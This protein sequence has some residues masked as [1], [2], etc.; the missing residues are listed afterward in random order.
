MEISYVNHKEI[1]WHT[2]REDSKRLAIC[3]NRLK[4]WKTANSCWL[5][6]CAAGCAA[7]CAA[8]LLA[9][10]LLA[11]LLAVSL[12]AVSL[13]VVPASQALHCSASFF[14]RRQ[15]SKAVTTCLVT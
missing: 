2:P 5:C 10:S 6:C 13:L 11:A 3:F 8:V 7:G 12:L 4:I 9:V 14:S 1:T 15:K